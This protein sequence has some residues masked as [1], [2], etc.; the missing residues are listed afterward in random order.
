[1]GFFR[2]GTDGAYPELSTI[3]LRKPLAVFEFGVLEDPSQGNKS[4]WIQGALQ[5]IASV[6]YPRIKAI[7][8][9][10]EEW[11][12]WHDCMCTWTKWCDKPKIRFL[13]QNC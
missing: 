3:S 4:A 5:S 11:N 6:K 13:A 12:D 7:S 2:K 8:Y 1:M 9:W 10:N